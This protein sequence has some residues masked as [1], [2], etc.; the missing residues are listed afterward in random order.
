MTEPAVSPLVEVVDPAS[1][2]SLQAWVHMVGSD[3]I[4][5][6]GGGDRPHVGCVVLAVPTPGRSGTGYSPSV[7]VLTIPPHKEEPIA[8]AV[9]EEICRRH[10]R[11]ATV[12]A[13]VHEDDIDR[14]AI[15]TYLR[16]GGELADAVAR[17]VGESP[18]T[19]Q[20]RQA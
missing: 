12:T 9:A 19:L 11:V 10:G 14:E 13:G 5:A 1:G 3:V 2:R 8:R 16:L 20:Y 6:V 7:S 15:E 4:V 18:P 17:R